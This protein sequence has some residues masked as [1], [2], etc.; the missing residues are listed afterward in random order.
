MGG[1]KVESEKHTESFPR[2]HENEVWHKNYSGEV[3]VAHDRYKLYW[4]LLHGYGFQKL[5][6]TI[7]EWLTE[8]QEMVR[9]GLYE[10]LDEVPNFEEYLGE[11]GFHG[12]LWPCL[13]E[14]YEAEYQDAKMREELSHFGNLADTEDDQEGVC[15]QCGGLVEYGMRDTTD[16]GILTHW[17]CPKCGATGLE[18]AKLVFERH[19]HVRMKNGNP[20]DGRLDDIR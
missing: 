18:G 17:D 11:Q 3:R 9:D 7:A 2:V 4:L 12:E 5:L 1:K 6:I 14:F 8:A 13:G 10:S 16:E 20:V 19:Y 15:P